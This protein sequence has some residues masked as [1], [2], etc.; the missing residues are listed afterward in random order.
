VSYSRYVLQQG[1]DYI[2]VVNPV[3]ASNNTSARTWTDL[4]SD[5]QVQGDPF[6]NSPNGELGPQSNVNFGRT[7]I[8]TRSDP[9]LDRGFGVRPYNW[10]TS[11]GI[12]H[13][14]F[15]GVSVTA[16]YFRRWFG[17]FVVTENL[18]TLPTDYDPYCITAPRDARLPDGG[19]YQVCGLYDVNPSK[20]GRIDNLRT[21]AENYGKQSENWNGFDLT[22]NARLTGGVI[23]QGGVSSGKTMTDACEIARRYPNVT[24]TNSLNEGLFSGNTPAATQVAQF[25]HIE[26]PWLTNVRFVGAYP[27]PYGVQVSATFQNNFGAAMYANYVATNAVVAPSLGRNLAAGANSS[28]TLNVVEQGTMY[29]DRMSQL[30]V[31]VTKEFRVGQAR[32]RGMVDLYNTLNSNTVLTANNTYGTNGAAWRVPQVILAGRIVKF[33][34]QLN[35]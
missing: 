7:V 10:E 16:T 5:F 22:M 13:E 4:N 17:N 33:A 34:A 26:T 12:Q 32:I 2:A 9:E 23:L 1:I 29:L 8:T 31:R 19:G 11:A 35:F 28:V 14:L 20:F 21:K 25:C 15:N 30:D 18:A 6:N 3:L 27:L 24:Y